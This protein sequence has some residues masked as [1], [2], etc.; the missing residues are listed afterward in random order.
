[1]ED[2]QVHPDVIGKLWQVYSKYSV[3][4]IDGRYSWYV[5]R[6]RTAATTNAEAGRYHY[7]RYAC[8]CEEICRVGACGSPREDWLRQPGQGSVLENESTIDTDRFL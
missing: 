4:F 6:L 7:S 8:S 3:Y 5:C 2:G 1:M